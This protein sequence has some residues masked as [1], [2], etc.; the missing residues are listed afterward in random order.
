MYLD[1]RLDEETTKLVL[2]QL[3]FLCDSATLGLRVPFKIRHRISRFIYLVTERDELC[4][5]SPELDR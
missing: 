4:K 3:F 2:G 5:N 1:G